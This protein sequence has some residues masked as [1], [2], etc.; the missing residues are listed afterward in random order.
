MNVLSA[1]V[2]GLDGEMIWF[3]VT[4]IVIVLVVGGG[5]VIAFRAYSP[6]RRR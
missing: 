4:T 3:V 2:L 1:S 5:M 6:H